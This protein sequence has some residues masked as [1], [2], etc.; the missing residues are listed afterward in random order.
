MPYTIKVAT[1]DKCECCIAYRLI[2]RDCLE[3]SSPITE[4]N[5]EVSRP[6]MCR[7]Q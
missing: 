7:L 5:H 4:N 2:Q 3:W 6:P 1:E